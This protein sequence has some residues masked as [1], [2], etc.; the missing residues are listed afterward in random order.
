MIFSGLDDVLILGNTDE[1]SDSPM[2]NSCVAAMASFFNEGIVTRLELDGPR[3]LD[4]F[5]R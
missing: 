1:G 3:R 4:G 5:R 2:M